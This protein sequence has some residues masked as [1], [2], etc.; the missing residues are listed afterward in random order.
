MRAAQRTCYWGLFIGFCLSAGFIIMVFSSTR[1][2]SAGELVKAQ[3]VR[4]KSSH[5]APVAN[6]IKVFT[7]APAGLDTGKRAAAVAEGNAIQVVG[8]DQLASFHFEVTEDMVED[9]GNSSAASQEI[10]VQI[11]P[12]IKAL[13]EQQV[14]V[15]GFMLPVTVQQGLVT[16]FMI[17]KSP[18]F[19]CYGIIPKVNEWVTVH[20]T[21]K[22]VKAVTDR[23]VC[24]SGRLHVGENRENGLLVGIYSMDAER[25]KIP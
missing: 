2:Y 12:A 13:D 11:P 25:L 20:M 6:D 18:A 7:T 21:G 17:A 5:A 3:V 22:G 9:S 1:T 14:L 8:F 15:T 19:C 23:P 24:V 16:D 10:A 4:G